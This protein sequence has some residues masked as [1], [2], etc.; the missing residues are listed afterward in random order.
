MNTNNFKNIHI[1]MARMSVIMLIFTVLF[2][3][4][5]PISMAGVPFRDVP[6]N[7]FFHD[8]VVWAY[9]N[10]ITTGTS[11]NTFSPNNPVTRGQFVT[12]LY[13]LEGEPNV[14]D[15]TIFSDVT[16]RGAFFFSAVTWAYNRGITTGHRDRTFRPNNPITR[17]EMT[18]MLFRYAAYTGADLTSSVSIFNQ[19]PDRSDV[20]LWARDAMQWATYHGIVAGSGGR[21]LPSNDTT[22]GQTVTVLHRAVMSGVLYGDLDSNVSNHVNPLTGLGSVSDISS[23]RPVAV[24]LGNTR[25][26]MPTNAINGLSQADIVYE[27]LIEDGHTRLVSIFQDFTDVQLVGSIRSV[28][29]YILDIAEAYDALLIHAGATSL[30]LRELAERN[31]TNFNE[32]HGP[33]RG[34]FSRNQYR[35]PGHTVGFYHS[36]VTSGF[37]ATR[38]FPAY[39]IRLTHRD[40]NF[41]LSFTDNPIPS[42]GNRAHNVEIRFSSHKTS[43]FTF[44]ERHNR[45]HMNQFDRRVT[46]ANNNASVAFANLLI[47]RMN[48]SL[49]DDDFELSLD[50]IG[51]GIGY[52]V[53]NGRV[54]AINWSRECES[55]PF[56][57][58]LNDGSAVELGRGRTYIGI[59]PTDMSVIFW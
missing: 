24:S 7:V 9:S 31:I 53:S 4:I 2:T 46:D 50:T 51:T 20:S 37:D 35:I 22:R 38:R 54:I 48:V 34:I 3:L 19:F 8:A 25:D 57:Y 16:N 40:S 43:T 23:K 12:F 10:T 30:T 13:R 33:R 44:N 14:T 21:L 52:F 27:L 26:G 28:R 32:V 11:P 39:R 6:T 49:L 41:G 42:G 18:T 56:V 29:P 17:E 1:K 45:F 47:L 59:I 15:E 5:T 36:A 58:T 55:S